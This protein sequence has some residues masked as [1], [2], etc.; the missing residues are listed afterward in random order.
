MVSRGKSVPFRKTNKR[1][2]INQI[3]HSEQDDSAERSLPANNS[4][5]KQQNYELIESDEEQSLLSN[6]KI[7]GATYEQRFS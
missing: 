2:S 3:H 5:E 1:Q 4:R 6:G 7:G